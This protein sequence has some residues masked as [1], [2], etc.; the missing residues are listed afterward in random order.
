[1][2]YVVSIEN[3]AYMRWQVDILYES[4]RLLGIED[5]LFILCC[6][7]DGEPH[8]LPYERVFHHENIGRRFAY[9]PF[10]KIYGLRKALAAG[11]IR[12]PFVVM[13]PDMF[14]LHPIPLLD[15]DISANLTW[16]LDYDRLKEDGYN[17]SELYGVSREHWFPG[18]TIYQFR[19]ASPALFD[20]M[21]V[22]LVDLEAKNAARWERDMIATAGAISRSGL[23][24]GVVENFEKTLNPFIVGG[25]HAAFVVHY[26]HG[27]RNRF[28]KILHNPDRGFSTVNS[29]EPWEAILALPESVLDMSDEIDRTPRSFAAVTQMKAIVRSLL[30]RKK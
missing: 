23:K 29:W 22:N 2:D 12:C 28:N 3:S 4:M 24:L 27:F 19:N 10:N 25:D 16:Y 17:P 7:I 18:G 9:A 14:F 20:Q 1:M 30:E 8:P 13:D 11:V 21:M 6:P 5:K 15:N 26:C